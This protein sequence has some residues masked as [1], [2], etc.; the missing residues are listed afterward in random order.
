M[1]SVYEWSC[2]VREIKTDTE[3][4]MH[5]DRNRFGLKKFFSNE[6]VGCGLKHSGVHVAWCSVC[7]SC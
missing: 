5:V 4:K 2:D 1:P 3:P 7:R 6:N